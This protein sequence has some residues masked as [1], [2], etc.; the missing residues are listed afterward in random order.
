MKPPIHIT[1]AG[2]M[3]RDKRPSLLQL[4][5]EDDIKH[6]T[7]MIPTELWT[8]NGGKYHQPSHVMMDGHKEPV[9]ILS[10]GLSTGVITKETKELK[11]I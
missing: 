9:N 2:Q 11:T 7:S 1:T 6:V 8:C 5:F 3:L 4:I 10:Y